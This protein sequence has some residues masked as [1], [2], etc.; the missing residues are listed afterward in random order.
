MSLLNQVGIGALS[1]GAGGFAG[2]F[3]GGTFGGLAVGQ[4]WGEALQSGLEAGITGAALGVALG[5]AAPLVVRAGHA[6]WRTRYME[7]YH[8]TSREGAAGIRQTGIDLSRSRVKLDYGKGFYTTTDKAQAAAWAARTRGGGEVMKF[9]ALKSAVRSLRVKTF[10]EA[11]AEW[12]GFVRSN[13]LG[14]PMHD[15]DV[16]SGPMLKNVGAFLKGDAPVVFGQQTSWH[17][18]RAVSLLNLVP[19]IEVAPVAGPI[20]VAGALSAAGSATWPDED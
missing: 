14:V 1:G 20:G 19:Q 10:S 3:A 8:G 16:V 9:R 15:Y 17:T 6:L 2:G 12:S 11:S 18:S 5:A 7:V 13:R 4:S